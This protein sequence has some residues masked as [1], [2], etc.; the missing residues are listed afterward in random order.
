MHTSPLADNDFNYLV[1]A[2]AVVLSMGTFI[3]N[4]KKAACASCRE[5]SMILCYSSLR[6]PQALM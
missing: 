1:H 6:V 4:N 2:A 5:G 3:L